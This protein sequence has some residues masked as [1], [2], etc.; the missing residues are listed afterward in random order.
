MTSARS[1]PQFESLLFF[2]HYYDRDGFRSRIS[3]SSSTTF[4]HNTKE[5]QKRG[6]FSIEAFWLA[7]VNGLLLL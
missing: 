2:N 3:S 6:P 5:K 7:P 1:S 4:H